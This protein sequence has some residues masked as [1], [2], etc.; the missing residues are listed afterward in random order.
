MCAHAVRVTLEKLP[1]VE[2]AVVSL[3]DGR[4]S[5]SLSGGNTVTMA[6]I[7]QAVERNGFT[8]KQ[9]F[10]RATADVAG[11]SPTIQ[12]TIG[13]KE[14]YD[15]A[16]TPHTREVLQQLRGMIGQRVVIEGVIPARTDPGAAPMIHVNSVRP[17]SP[18]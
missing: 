9:A 6:Q 15:V 10:V 14:T 2:S 4:V 13:A 11:T 12:L 8:P 18:R 5:L 17:A 7:R 16:V 1:G 3:N